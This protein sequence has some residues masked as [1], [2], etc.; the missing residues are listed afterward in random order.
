MVAIELVK[1]TIWLRGLVSDMG[2]QQDETIVFYDSQNAIHLIKNQMYHKRTK[3]IDVRYY[4]LREVVTYG[5]IILKKIVV[6]ENSTDMLT[7]LISALKLKN[8]LG[9]IDVCSL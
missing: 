2:L 1:E 5:D 9:L 4:F 6:A 7:I 3:H 8:C